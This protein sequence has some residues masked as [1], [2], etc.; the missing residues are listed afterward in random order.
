MQSMI[1]RPENFDSYADYRRA[2]RDWKGANA[3]MSAATSAQEMTEDQKEAILQ[4]LANLAV[5]RRTRIVST[6]LQHI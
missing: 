1:V 3:E 5:S 4:G 2:V 6:D